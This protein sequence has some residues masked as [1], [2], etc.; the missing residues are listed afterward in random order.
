MEAATAGSSILSV[1]AAEAAPPPGADGTP[2][3][4]KDAVVQALD[5][6]NA[7]PPE[8]APQKYWDP[9]TKTVKVEDLGRSYINL[10]KL[11]GREKVPVPTSDDDEEGW[12]RWYAASGRPESPDKYEFAR[13]DKLPDG[14]DYDEDL[15]KNYR[16]W[17]HQNG[18]N[19]KQAKAFY[20]GWVKTQVEKHAAWQDQVRRTRADGLQ[21]L[22]RA[23]GRQ[24]DVVISD[25]KVGFRHA[26][27]EA[28][29]AK[30][31]AY[32]LDN[33]P[34]IVRAFAKVGRELGGDR[35]I[36]GKPA[37]ENPA[38]IEKAMR[39]FRDKHKEAL[40]DKNHPDHAGRVK[41]LE[42]LYERR[43]PENAR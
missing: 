32:G 18:L 15:E 29:E 31:K 28:L 19:K 35:R 27:D 13:P 5:D 26:G 11:L 20:D 8:W 38:D 39:D 3:P 36:A 14:L 16:Q 12:H 21:A 41:E 40:F 6:A 4:A 43:F 22:A 2:A 34:D 37:A 25:A 9:K 17:A 42:K 33:D 30:L 7:A 23:E 24:L 10:E 1:T